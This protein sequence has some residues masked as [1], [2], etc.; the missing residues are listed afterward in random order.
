[1]KFFTQVSIA[2]LPVQV[3]LEDRIMVLGSCFADGVGERMK[4]AGFNVCINPFG[5]LYNP[6]SILN[7]VARLES[8]TPFSESD[9]VPMGAGAG[10]VC[11][12]SHH[13]SFARP[14]EAEFLE[15]ANG[16][17]MEASEFWHSCNKVIITLG[18]AWVWK[19]KSLISDDETNKYKSLTNLLSTE[20][21]SFG[22]VSNC[23]KRPS[24]EFQ[25]EMLGIDETKAIIEDLKAAFP[26]KEFIFTVSPIRHLSDG[27]HS[28]TLSK[29]TL[30]LAIG[31]SC[32]FPAFELLND[33]LRDYRFYAD[34]LVHPSSAAVGFIWERFIESAVPA[35]YHDRIRE[36]EKAARFTAHRQFR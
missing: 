6:A 32:Y 10:L 22:V 33:E 3:G 21:S 2:P 11:S 36:N 35:K 13:T 19:A 34:D 30:H 17:L 28:N 23:L 18:T 4:A 27:A 24:G 16:K 26:G 14:T 5:T 7:S 9:C 20:K 25:R 15:N 31:S 12:Y 1:M 29:A 8:G